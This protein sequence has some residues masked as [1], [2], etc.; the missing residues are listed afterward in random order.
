MET[1]VLVCN[2][3]W[4]LWRWQL[5]LQWGMLPPRPS[6][7]NDM[8]GFIF[9]WRQK[10]VAS[11]WF[12]RL[13][14]GSSQ[15]G[16]LGSTKSKWLFTQMNCLWRFGLP[17]ATNLSLTSCSLV[18]RKQ[19][20]LGPV[21]LL[22]F[23]WQSL[24]AIFQNEMDQGMEDAILPLNHAGHFAVCLLSVLYASF[25]PCISVCCKGR[26]HMKLILKSNSSVV[27]MGAS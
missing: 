27:S 7:W 18:S 6:S 14:A 20:N 11:G 16:F 13:C 3:W 19:L 23:E 2:T 17:R 15:S 8:K 22:L 21:G 10:G 4:V 12:C 1:Q 24:D 9:I 26:L 25:F 5:W